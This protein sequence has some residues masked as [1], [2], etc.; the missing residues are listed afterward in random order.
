MN[1]VM[2]KVFGVAHRRLAY[3]PGDKVRR[4]AAF[5]LDLRVLDFLFTTFEL[6]RL[7][8]GSKSLFFF[9]N[10]RI[11]ILHQKGGSL[12]RGITGE[13]SVLTDGLTD[14]GQGR[15]HLFAPLRHAAIDGSDRVDKF[16]RELGS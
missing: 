12:D 1:D 8:S 5:A 4:I 15:A 7:P 2:Q 16:R 11:G 10:V 3:S 13:L 9:R 6:K 14:D